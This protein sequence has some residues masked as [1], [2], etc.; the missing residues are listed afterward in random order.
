MQIPSG[1]FFLPDAEHISAVIFNSAATISKFNRMGVISGFGS[2]DVTLVVE[3][4]MVDPDEGATTPMEFAQVVGPDYFE[5]WIDGTDVFHNPRATYPL[6]PELLPEAAHHHLQP[7]ATMLSLVPP[8]KLIGSITT[9][10][11]LGDD[12]QTPA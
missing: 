3:G 10:L 5:R 9:V 8:G 7:D 4:L 2:D 6:D 12:T 11:V 1:F